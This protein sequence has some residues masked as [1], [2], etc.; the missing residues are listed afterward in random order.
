MPDP[1]LADSW[2]D[3][4]TGVV[5]PAKLAGIPVAPGSTA[6]PNFGDLIKDEDVPRFVKNVK[7]GY[8]W[9]DASVK[10][11]EEVIDAV[12]KAATSTGNTMNAVAMTNVVILL[13]RL[14]FVKLEM[15]SSLGQTAQMGQA[16]STLK[17][18]LQP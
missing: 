10:T 11:V 1:S 18:I 16:L 9:D 14:L 12:V 13:T 4:T 17:Q 7:E 3:L 5:D 6:P 15:R 8:N 2:N